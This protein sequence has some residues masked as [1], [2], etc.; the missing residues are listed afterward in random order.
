MWQK[1]SDLSRNYK[2]SPSQKLF[3]RKSRVDTFQYLKKFV[4]YPND[5]S[6]NNCTASST[7]S[8]GKRAR[9]ITLR[10]D[11]QINPDYSSSHMN[12]VVSYQKKILEIT[13]W[14]LNFRCFSFRTLTF[15]QSYIFANSYFRWFFFAENPFRWKV[16][17]W[18][19]TIPIL[20]IY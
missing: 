20:L 13:E 19:A 2:N 7:S 8:T 18:N 10:Q 11:K 16:F 3:V 12:T 9:P 5:S 15:S 17:R 1:I 14:K 4:I 6:S